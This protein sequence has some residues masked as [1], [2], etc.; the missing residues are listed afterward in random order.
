MQYNSAVGAN[1][2]QSAQVNQ[3]RELHSSTVHQLSG[4][5]HHRQSARK[6]I[7]TE[8]CYPKP[9]EL[10][11]PPVYLKNIVSDSGPSIVTNTIH[12]NN[13]LG[14]CCAFHDDTIL[15]RR[16]SGDVGFFYNQARV[17]TLSQCLVQA[18]QVGLDVDVAVAR[19]WPPFGLGGGHWPIIFQVEQGTGF[20]FSDTVERL[21]VD[22]VVT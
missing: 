7:K 10:S 20:F 18:P 16:V 17:A 12:R 22:T 3:H 2:H 4:A 8:L 11:S 14:R 6:L 9:I 5:N 13:R 15:H 21:E 19:Y 1:H